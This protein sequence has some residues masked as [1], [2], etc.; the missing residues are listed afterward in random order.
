[1]GMRGPTRR[2]LP[3]SPQPPR[4]TLVHDEAAG[5]W[6]VQENGKEIGVTCTEE[7]SARA[8]VQALNLQRAMLVGTVLRVSPP[9]GHYLN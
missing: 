2:P 8:V 7:G 1:M 3:A 9:R 4:Y 5:E 6:R